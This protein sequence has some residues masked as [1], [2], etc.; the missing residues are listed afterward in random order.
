MQ[1]SKSGLQLTERFEGVRLSAY[2]DTAG[3]WTIGYGHTHGVKQGDTCTIEQA[4]QWL[5]EDTTWA[6]S[7]VN[8]LVKVTLTQPIFDSLVDFTFNLGSGNFQHSQ[9]LSLINQEKFEEA[10]NEFDKWDR[11]GGQVVAGL[12]R[13]RNAEKEEFEAGLQQRLLSPQ[14]D[15]TST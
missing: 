13:R 9:L 15:R 2:Q 6:V 7:V 11:A 14:P 3:V 8:A 12:L 10:A 5:I 1:Y 4:E